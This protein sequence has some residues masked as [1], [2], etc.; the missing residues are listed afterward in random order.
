MANKRK[1]TNKQKKKN[2]ARGYMSNSSSNKHTNQKPSSGISVSGPSYAKLM[3]LLEQSQ[4]NGSSDNGGDDDTDDHNNNRFMTAPKF[5]SDLNH[6]STRKKLAHLIEF[7]SDLKFDLDDHV[8]PCLTQILL[9]QI[10]LSEENALDWLCVNLSIEEL[11]GR[12]VDVQVKDSVIKGSS[13]S[14]SDGLGLECVSHHDKEV[15]IH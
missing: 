3:T 9:S 4:S 1:G 12:F 2:D 7:L 14:S 13:A 11:P 6:P 8:V 5:I 15:R 10:F